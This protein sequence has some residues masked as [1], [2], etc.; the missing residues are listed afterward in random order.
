MRGTKTRVVLG[1]RAVAAVKKA[2]RGGGAVLGGPPPKGKPD[3]RGIT[4]LADAMNALGAGGGPPEPVP[5]TPAPPDA[6]AGPIGTPPMAPGPAAG[7]PVGAT[8]GLGAG[9]GGLAVHPSMKGAKMHAYE[10]RHSSKHR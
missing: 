9:M 8:D 3:A 1:P 7:P 10:P 4:G 2:P 6:S 5:P